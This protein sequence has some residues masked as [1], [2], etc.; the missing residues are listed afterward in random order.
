MADWL[1][2]LEL[3]ELLAQDKGEDFD[4]AAHAVEIA[5]EVSKR[6]RDLMERTNKATATRVLDRQGDLYVELDEVADMLD[7]IAKFKPED[8]VDPQVA[9][10][11]CLGMLYD[12]GDSGHRVWV[13]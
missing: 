7:D 3:K 5:P 12:I 8:D 4:Y 2:T 10:N 9:L 6:V 13:K 1:Y 11:D